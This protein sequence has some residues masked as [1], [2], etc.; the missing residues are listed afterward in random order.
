MGSF[1][2]VDC[3]NFYVSCERLF[4]P[5]L[6]KRA[7]IVL[8]NNDGC[9]VARSQEAKEMGI[10]MGEPFFQI[11]DFCQDRFVSVFS[12]NYQL[13][14]DISRRIMDLLAKE[15]ECFQ[16]YSIDEAFLYY[17]ATVRS[18]E[19]LEHCKEMRRKIGKWIGIPVSCGIAPTKTLAKAANTCA[20]KDSSTGIFS[21][22]SADVQE[23]VLEKFPIGDVWGIGSRWEEKL[24]AKNIHTAKEF[25]EHDPYFMRQL[26]GVVGERILW[27]LRGKSCLSLEEA[28][29]KKSLTCSRS[30][31]KVVTE[32]KDLSEALATHVASAAEKLRA[33]GCC[34]GALF[35]YLEFLTETYNRQSVSKLL[36]FPIPTSDTSQMI[37]LA[38]SCLNE[39]YCKTKRYK[40][41]GVILLDLALEKN[42]QT[43]LFLQM[44][45][46]RRI[47][48][49]TM[50]AL[51][52]Q[53][54]KKRLFFAAEGVDPSWKMLSE[55]RSPRSTTSWEEI[56]I[57]RA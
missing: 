57:V 51:N 48:L 26:M 36:S 25:R 10:A 30:F 41:C 20:K 52:A 7:V 32:K 34:A 49:Q 17:P 5:Q 12:S 24:R 1:V 2:L 4:A 42:R 44:S 8:S 18:D 37:S 29:A 22:C 46:K 16:I 27:E 19:V 9:V 13:Y 54:G 45:A 6:E 21:L 3:N 47:A 40:K 39:L 35:V 38:K 56:A 31:G 28:G 50:D 53:M 15:A 33:Q 23:K 14:G 43:D 11:K 55:K